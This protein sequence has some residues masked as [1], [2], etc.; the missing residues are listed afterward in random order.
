MRLS[1][2]RRGGR[3][4]I[5]ASLVLIGLFYI[6]MLS[7]CPSPISPAFTV[8][9]NGND[10]TG[11][12]VPIDGNIYNSGAVV[13]V[14]GNTGHLLRTGYAFAGWSMQG[15]GGG[16]TY[17]AGQTLAMSNSNMT[18]YAVWTTNASLNALVINEVGNPYYTNYSVAIELYNTSISPVDLSNYLLRTY[19]RTNDGS[20]YPSNGIATF[21][22]PSLTIPGGGYVVIRGKVY[23]SYV[24]GGATVYLDN[25]ASSSPL[26]PWDG[27][28]AGFVELLD[29]SGNTIDFIRWGSDSTQPTLSSFTFNGTAP[30]FSGGTAFIGYSL[31][32]DINSSD[33]HRASDWTIRA[34]MTLGGPNDVTTDTASDGDGIPDSAKAVNGTFAGLPLYQWGARQG[35]KDIFLHIDYMVSGSVGSTDAG[36]IPQ[37]AAMDKVKEAFAAKGYVIHFDV[38]D[39]FSASAGDTANYNLDGRSHAVPLQGSATLGAAANYAN[40]YQYKVTYMPGAKRQVFFY[41]LFGDTQQNPASGGSSGLA[42]ISGSTALITLGHWGLSTSPSAN[43][44]ELLNFQ[45]STMMHEFGHNLGLMHGGDE[46]TNYKPNYFSIMNYLYQLNGLPTI[47]ADDDTRY[48]SQYKTHN[49]S[50]SAAW[51]DKANHNLWTDGPTST[52][53]AM[54]YSSGIGGAIEESAAVETQGIRRAGS[55]GI[56]FNNDG[57]IS[58]IGETVD[59]VYLLIGTATPSSSNPLHDFNDWTAI[60]SVFQRQFSGFNSGASLS[61]V[62]TPAS[63]TPSLQEIFNNPNPEVS[64]PCAPKP[65][66]LP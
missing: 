16:T 13:T 41:M 11:G 48:Y 66:W 37:K 35:Q 30:A 62:A 40:A 18:L 14:Q 36:I 8:T 59:P 55:L 44:N 32:R 56:D 42:N 24:S 3:A 1:D 51:A 10:A 5:K 39:L 20:S 25:G 22:L 15:N 64:P 38:G 9:Y 34:W 52:S 23:G 17:V 19:S 12:S 60:S 4:G 63:T 2:A 57:A 50:I 65:P 29:T 31:G 6:G 21:A 27:Y 61:K 47:G 43:L 58:G 54:D 53:F 45:A 7:N 26:Y 49:G 28:N 33:T 46:S